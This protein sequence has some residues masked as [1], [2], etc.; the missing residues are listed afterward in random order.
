MTP[1]VVLTV[2]GS[3]SGGAAGIAAD[4]ATFAAL[5]VH[6]ACAIAAVTA[7]DTCAVH[8]VYP[9]PPE[10][11]AAQIGA[12]FGDLPVAAAKTGLLGSTAAVDLVARRLKGRPLVVDPVL[13]ATSGANFAT[14]AIIDAYRTQLLPVATVATPNLDEARILARNPHGAPAELAQALADLGLSVVVTG[15]T[16]A[17]ACTDWLARPGEPARPFTHAAVHTQNDHGTGCTF[18]AALAAHL[19]H[20]TDLVDAVKSSAAYTTRQLSVSRAWQL[21]RGS[22]PISHLHTPHHPTERKHQ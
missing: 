13:T 6:G 19:A 11:L 2:A 5:G 7:Q 17:G 14:D 1:P 3:D 20:G 8:A 22:G 4:L 15:G 18:S 21:G 10:I 12:V 16:Q 9:I